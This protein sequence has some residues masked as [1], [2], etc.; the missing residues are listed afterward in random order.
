MRTKISFSKEQVLFI[1][2]CTIIYHM[3]KTFSICCLMF[4][5]AIGMGSCRKCYTC[6]LTTTE[7]INSRDSTVVLNTQVCD[8]KNGAGANLNVA[9]QDIEANG[10]ICTSK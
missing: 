10:Y 4:L 9:V 3:R 8:G 5:L 2:A 1:L 7:L 6:T